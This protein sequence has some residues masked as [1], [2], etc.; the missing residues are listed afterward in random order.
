MTGFS[1]IFKEIES[2]IEVLDN[3]GISLNTYI[4]AVDNILLNLAI[5]GTAKYNVEK[6]LKIVEENMNKLI[7]NVTCVSSVLLNAIYQYKLSEGKVIAK[8]TDGSGNYSYSQ[9]NDSFHNTKNGVTYKGSYDF[10][11]IET[12]Y[13]AKA[14]FEKDKRALEASASIKATLLKGEVS[15][16]GE[17]GEVSAQAAAGVVSSGIAASIYAQKDENGKYRAG[18]E[19]KASASAKG[20]TGSVSGRAGTSKNNVHATAS[21]TLGGA[22]AEAKVGV[23]ADATGKFKA[24]AKA[25]AEAYA[26]KGEVKGGITIFGIKI[27]A[28]VEGKAGAIGAKAGGEVSNSK[29]SVDVGG[30]LGLGVGVKISVDWSDFELPKFKD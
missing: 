27:D 29:A 4:S 1:I 2:Q 22:E 15:A 26:A 8:K 14:K 23:K 10:A 13:G 5:E 30:S 7:S 24:Y 25:G 28:A 21:G 17:Y 11:N 18:A 3:I 6:Q 9:Q 16:S 20:L 19:V 12:D